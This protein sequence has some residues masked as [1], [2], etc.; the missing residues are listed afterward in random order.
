MGAQCTI[1]G[2]VVFRV[3]DRT[4]G[5]SSFGVSWIISFRCRIAVL[6]GLHTIVHERYA[7]VWLF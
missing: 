7:W 3:L 5:L 2:A 6:I 4:T 1:A